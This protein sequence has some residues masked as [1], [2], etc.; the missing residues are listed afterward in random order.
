MST[1]TQGRQASVKVFRPTHVPKELHPVWHGAAAHLASSGRLLTAS[2][3]VNYEA[4]NDQFIRVLGASLQMGRKAAAIRLA[5][6]PKVSRNASEVAIAAPQHVPVEMRPIWFAAARHASRKGR[7]VAS[8]R[9]INYPEVN[10]NY[11]KA[12]AAYIDLARKASSKKSSG[13]AS[14]ATKDWPFSDISPTDIA[15][16]AAAGRWDLVEKAARTASRFFAE[17]R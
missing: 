8:N 5:S 2:G 15:R 16:F 1:I 4:V 10:N 9:A 12:V 13:Q 3:K 6:L 7:L 11:M 14:A 17:A